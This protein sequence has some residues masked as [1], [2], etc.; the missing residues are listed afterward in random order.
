MLRRRVPEPFAE[1]HPETATQYAIGDGD[2][3]ALSTPQ[4]SIQ[5]RCKLT[6]RTQ[7]GVIAAQTGW[8]EPCEELD[9]PGYDPF[10]AEG[11]NVCLII[12]NDS[13]DPISGSVPAKAYPCNIARA[14]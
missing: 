13:L 14:S 5:L 2:R 1:I 7:P 9:L 12:N 3:V 11:A 4:G 8:W 10:S 6:E